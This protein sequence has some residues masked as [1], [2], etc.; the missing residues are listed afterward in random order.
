MTRSDRYSWRELNAVLRDLTEDDILRLIENETEL[1]R[2]ITILR[3][4]HQRYNIVRM[5]RERK[6]LNQQAT[7]AL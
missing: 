4:L 2:R 1:H 5:K 6:E 7:I 3:R